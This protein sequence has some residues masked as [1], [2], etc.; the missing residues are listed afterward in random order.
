MSSG[1]RILRVAIAANSSWLSKSRNSLAF[2]I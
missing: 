1:G 2:H